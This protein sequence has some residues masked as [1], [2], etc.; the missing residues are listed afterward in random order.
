MA[1]VGR[2]SMAGVVGGQLFF[3]HDDG[4]HGSE[5]WVV[6]VGATARPVGTGC[7]V[8]MR[9]PTIGA[10]DPVLGRPWNLRGGD[11]EPGSIGVVLL[12][13]P[14][15]PPVVHG[16]GCVQYVDPGSATLLLARQDA[17]LP[18]QSSF[19]LPDLP[20]LYGQQL[21]VQWFCGPSRNPS[22]IEASPGLWLSL[23]NW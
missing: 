14:A 3:E 19:P 7:G 8:G 2:T 1:G 16:G 18:W 9:V 4:Q 5:P 12:G 10:D 20:L 23:D 6:G 21:C 13:L 22:G 11:G 15:S 17:A